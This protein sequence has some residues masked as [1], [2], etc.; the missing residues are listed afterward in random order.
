MKIFYGFSAAVLVLAFIV[1][2]GPL[3]AADQDITADSIVGKWKEP[4]E[5][6]VVQI[7]NK[8]AYYEGAVVESPSH[9]D[10]VSTMIFKNL[11]YNGAKGVWK[12]QVY[13]IERKKDYDVEIKMSDT[14]MFTMKAKAG[15]LSKTIEWSRVP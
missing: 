14:S 4:D 9:P 11:V 1:F 15:L 12:G 10:G 13:S 5:D 2:G 7:E 8:G 6:A 3:S